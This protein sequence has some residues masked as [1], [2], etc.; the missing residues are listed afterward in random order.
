MS[1]GTSPA[2]NFARVN[3]VYQGVLDIAP[4]LAADVAAVE[5]GLVVVQAAAVGLV[6]ERAAMAPPGAVAA[7][8]GPAAGLAAAPVAGA[9]GPAGGADAIAG[10]IPEPAAPAPFGAVSFDAGPAAAPAAAPAQHAA[11]PANAAGPAAAPAAAYAN[12]PAARA[13]A[14][15]QDL[16]LCFLL[17]TDGV[18]LQK[19]STDTTVGVFLMFADLP[20]DMVNTWASALARSRS[21]CDVPAC[22]VIADWLINLFAPQARPCAYG[23]VP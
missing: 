7:N 11:G 20:P 12:S 4:A 5:P 22:T 10:L 3:A 16:V 23:M 14:A 19:H 15:G 8:A 13:R 1:R 17:G 18:Q 2:R 21:V 9:G 6:P